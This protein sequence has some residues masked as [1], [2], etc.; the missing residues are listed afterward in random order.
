MLRAWGPYTA[1]VGIRDLGRD[2]FSGC[3]R[4][5]NLY[6]VV[7][8]QR[9]CKGARLVDLPTIFH[10]DPVIL[11]GRNLRIILPGFSFGLRG[12]GFV[13]ARQDEGTPLQLL[14]AKLQVTLRLPTREVFIDLVGIPPHF[15]SGGWDKRSLGLLLV[16]RD[17]T[18]QVLPCYAVLPALGE[19]DS[20]TG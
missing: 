6:I 3:A 10:R 17:R 9:K 5:N 1:V 11:R 18:R 4:S 7:I 12:L 13:R 2:W 19:L 15:I 14:G 8:E 16:L 20:L